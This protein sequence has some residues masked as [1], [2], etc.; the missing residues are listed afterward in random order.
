M[1]QVLT[2]QFPYHEC[3]NDFQIFRA[4][5]SGNLPTRPERDPATELDQIDDEMW[6][7]M[8]LCWA[9]KP[10]DRPTFK[11]ILQEL[12]RKGLVRECEGEA[13]ETAGQESWQFQTAMKT[14]D[15]KIDLLRVEQILNE[16]RDLLHRFNS[17]N[18]DNTPTPL[19]LV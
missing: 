13:S 14:S 10:Q 11:Q 5:T 4:L 18:P 17:A 2:R 6:E 15:A 12:E 7:L 19:A 9:L 8:N 16:V 3:T 1:V